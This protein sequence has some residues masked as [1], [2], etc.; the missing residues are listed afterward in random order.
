MTTANAELRIVRS[1]QS[2]DEVGLTDLINR[3]DSTNLISP[4]EL[5]KQIRHII[6][7]G[8]HSWIVSLG[9]TP[10]GYATI[11]PIPGLPGIYDL[12]CTIVQQYRRQG[13][14]S[15]LVNI[16]K[17]ELQN[18]EVLQL[19]YAVDSIESPA[20]VFLQKQGFFVEHVEWS[21]VL[22]DLSDLPSPNLLSPYVLRTF[23]KSTAA[24][25]FN[26]LYDESFISMPWYQP[27]Q[28]NQEVMAELDDPD[29][30]LFLWQGEEP[31]GFAWL[32][33][34][35]SD[36][37]EIEPIGII[38]NYRGKGLGRTLLVLALH[39]LKKSGAELVRLG[40]WKS[41]TT[42]VHL[43]QSH[44]FERQLHLIYLATK[45]ER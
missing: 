36:S 4:A 9:N 34:N 25:L 40:V 6:K 13:L 28:S 7:R 2:G 15:D 44:G 23:D 30:M 20:A 8:G 3:S 41:N 11:A 24:N 12:S 21:M 37:A 16:I 5:G 33:W 45:I 17:K 39:R 43:Y 19:S 1:Y 27:Y 31:I 26:R 14:G 18:S 29:N 32:R 35:G 10:V 22:K 42:A 38:D